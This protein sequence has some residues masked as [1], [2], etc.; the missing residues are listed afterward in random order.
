MPALLLIPFRQC[1]GQCYI[2]RVLIL[3]RCTCSAFLVSR[4]VKAIS[5]GARDLTQTR[6]TT[7]WP[8]AVISLVSVWTAL[9]TSP[10]Q[11]CGCSPFKMLSGLGLRNVYGSCRAIGIAPIFCLLCYTSLSAVFLCR[12]DHTNIKN[13]RLTG[14]HNS[15]PER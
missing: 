12:C 11:V 4:R 13:L 14:W 7:M 5:W 10:L 8:A 9:L 6:T 15:Y 3:L 2:S 1:H